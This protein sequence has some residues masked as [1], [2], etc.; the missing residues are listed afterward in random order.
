MTLV[1]VGRY[2]DPAT[3]QFL[4]VDPLVDQTG[5]PYA[6]T[7]GDPVNATDP[8]GNDFVGHLGNSSGGGP[9]LPGACGSLGY[10]GSG[11][12]SGSQGT[13][14]AFMDRRYIPQVTERLLHAREEYIFRAFLAQGYTPQQAAGVL[15]NLL[16][17][18]QYTLAPNVASGSGA[19]G[20]AQWTDSSRLRQ[21]A[22][23][24]AASDNGMGADDFK[25]QVAFIFPE[26]ESY[27]YP[28]DADLRAAATPTEAADAFM[29]G[30]EGP[31]SPHQ[32][33]REW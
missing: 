27:S 7:G 25:L 5:Q 8:T 14:L 22:A 1:S 13:L 12:E 23:Y 24:A 30:Y 29:N 10:S 9:L 18:S 16:V 15:G 2:Y 17:E 11:S 19:Y 20:I 28:G 3:G 6:Y 33:R 31:G 32:S 4:T 21:L 26:L